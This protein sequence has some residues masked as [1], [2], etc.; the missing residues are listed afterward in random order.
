MKA[1][2]PD[3]YWTA[4]AWGM[5]ISNGKRDTDLLADV[6]VV[7]ALIRRAFELDEAWGEGAIHEFL[8]AFE[9]RGEASGGSYERAR[10]HFKRAMALANGA[11]ITPLV[12]LAENVSQPQQNRKE[13]EQLLD[14]ALA[15][16][17]DSHVQTR[18][19]NILA[20]RRA[21]QLKAMIDDLFLE[22]K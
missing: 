16:D 1:D 12:S 10:T 18:L 22:V 15:Y 5:A 6:P 20:Q 9:S 11:R 17:V 13:F 3:L 14:E 2:V 4:A 19:Q 21:R 7:E 8:I